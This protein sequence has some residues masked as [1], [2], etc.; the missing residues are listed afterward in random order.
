MMYLSDFLCHVIIV[1]SQLKKNHDTNVNIEY[2]DDRFSQVDGEIV[3]CF[4]HLTEAYIFSVYI[5]QNGFRSYKGR[6]SYA[7]NFRQQ[8]EYST[9]QTLK[10]K[11]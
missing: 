6:N 9:P 10:V 4:K 5:T 1:L 11:F 3:F 7:F 8:K 2:D